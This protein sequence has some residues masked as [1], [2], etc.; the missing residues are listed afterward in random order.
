[1]NNFTIAKLRTNQ[2]QTEMSQFLFHKTNHLPKAAIHPKKYFMAR[3]P[4]NWLC[5]GKKQSKN[6]ACLTN[7]LPMIMLWHI[8]YN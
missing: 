7:K 5:I 4:Q 6:L 3:K 8:K 1:M 2:S